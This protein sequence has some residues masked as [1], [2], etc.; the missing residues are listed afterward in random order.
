MPEHQ[1]L[2]IDKDTIIRQQTIIYYL[3][4]VILEMLI[5]PAKCHILYSS[6]N[7]ILYVVRGEPGNKI[8]L[9]YEQQFNQNKAIFSKQVH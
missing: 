5:K 9:D 4:R 2:P 3:T 6:G 1:I 7:L 8:W